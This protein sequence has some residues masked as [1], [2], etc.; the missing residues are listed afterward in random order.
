MSNSIGQS[1][2]ERLL[3]SFAIL[4]AHEHP[5]DWDRFYRFVVLSHREGVGWDTGEVQIRLERLGVSATVAGEYA[6]IYWHARCVMHCYDNPG[7]PRA[8]Y[9]E[10]IGEHGVPLS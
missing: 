5:L 6:E 10:W 1:E 4:G 3:R 2:S 9:A 8:S 7:A